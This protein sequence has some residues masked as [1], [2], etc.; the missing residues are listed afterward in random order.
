MRFRW[1]SLIILLSICAGAQQT[2]LNIPS[3]D[4]LDK[5]QIYFR[6]D[7]SIFWSP[8]TAT[9]APNFIFGLG[10]NIEAG[11]NM[12]AFGI[13]AD[14]ANRSIVPNIKWK[15]YSTGKPDSANRLDLYAGNQV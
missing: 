4:V 11:I 2:I 3:A 14:T 8:E 10:H 15:F 9:T 1:L 13:P 12:N 6:L 7:T 5:K